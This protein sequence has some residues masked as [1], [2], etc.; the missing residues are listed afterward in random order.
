MA[1]T[2]EESSI[3]F[4]E[5]ALVCEALGRGEQHVIVRKGGIAEGR[6]GF[7]FK[8]EEFYLFPTLFHEQLARTTLPAGTLM[9]EDTGDTVRITYRVR[10]I[11]ARLVTD[12][13]AV[14]RLSPF[15]VLKPEIVEE[16]FHYDETPGVSVAL[17][18]V[19][20]LA[21]PWEF[22]M[23]RS[24]GG[25]RSWVTL[26]PRE[27]GAGADLPVVNDAAFAEIQRQVER[28]LPPGERG[29]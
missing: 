1:G 10:A 21:E 25:C 26:P 23:Q 2:S 3:G 17:V 12:P 14:R 7:Q 16:R 27:P 29:K 15:H 5:W 28:A 9:P 18:R 11:W 6:D 4:K 8:H 24:Y 22:S 19:S 13:E 20:R